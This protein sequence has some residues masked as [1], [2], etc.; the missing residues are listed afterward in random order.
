MAHFGA[1]VLSDTRVWRVPQ[2]RRPV[3]GEQR[4]EHGE[5]RRVGQAGLEHFGQ[6]F[7]FVC[8]FNISQ[9]GW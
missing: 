9:W 4:E 2:A 8:S 7:L 6:F 1:L 5:G 3:S